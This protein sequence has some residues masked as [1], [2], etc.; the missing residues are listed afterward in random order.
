MLG[1][2]STASSDDAVLDDDGRDDVAAQAVLPV[3]DGGC[4]QLEMRL[5]CWVNLYDCWVR[6]TWYLVS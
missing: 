3:L 4:I 6:E 2:C 1:C 5:L